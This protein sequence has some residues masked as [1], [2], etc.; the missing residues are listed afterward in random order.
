MSASTGTS[1]VGARGTETTGTGTFGVT[2][3]TGGAGT[4]NVRNTLAEHFIGFFV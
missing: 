4:L 2:E 1:T 3:T